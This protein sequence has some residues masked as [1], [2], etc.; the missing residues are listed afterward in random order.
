MK[1]FHD[2]FEMKQD[3][4]PDRISVAIPSQPGCERREDGAVKTS[5]LHK[6]AAFCILAVGAV[7]LVYAVSTSSA[8]QRDFISYWAAGKQL[9]HGANPYDS[10][11]ILALERGAGLD[12]TRPLLMRNPP[13]ALFLA[14]PLGL[15][16]SRTGMILWM[17]ILMGSLMASVR[18][19]WILF[20]RRNDRLH[21]LSY[22]F[23]PILAC[24]MAGQ[25]GLFILLGITLFL[26]IHKTRPV[27]AGSALLFC[28]IKPHLFLLFAV[29][30]L[31]WVLH[32]RAY[33]VLA[34]ALLA[35]LASSALSLYFDPHAFSHYLQMMRTGGVEQEFIPTLSLI[36]RILIDR[37][38]MWL[39]FVPAV[40]GG[41]WAL[42]YFRTRSDE[43]DWM[44][45][46]LLLLVVSVA[47][48][49]YAW[50]T[51]EAALLP[52]V[53][54][55]LYRAEDT[56]KPLWPFGVIAGAGMLEVISGV[57]MTTGFYIWTMPA[58]LAWYL[59][60]TRGRQS[61]ST[62]TKPSEKVNL[63]EASQ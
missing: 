55:A 39:Q 62:A 23:A 28:A 11:A 32:Q 44:N 41:I 13:V 26:Y 10:A 47:C 61:E 17:L 57:Q 18:M 25:V 19:I 40:V 54:A 31:A 38:L 15:A 60:A 12:G 7:I 59:Y 43:W 37:R 52:A 36:F 24:L 46:G 56:A 21:L 22:C 53:L 48:A 42:W 29:A 51:D 50:L 35:L 34:G 20:G 14:I 2:E 49:P 1:A 6:L 58:W 9:I 5:L 45:Q 8:G 3:S 27:L 16:P 30:F 4:G 33:R 63:N